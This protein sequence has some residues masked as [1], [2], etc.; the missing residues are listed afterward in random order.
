M[1]HSNWVDRARRFL[2]NELENSTRAT[3]EPELRI[4]VMDIHAALED[5]FRS[6][7]DAKF[8]EKGAL[9]KR[10]TSFPEI[11]GLLRQHTNVLGDEETVQNL[12]HFNRLRNSVVHDR[13]TP[14][15]AETL[16]FAE[17][18]STILKKLLEDQPVGVVRGTTERIRGYSHS[19]MQRVS[20]ITGRTEDSPPGLWHS[21]TS[22]AIAGVIVFVGGPLVLIVLAAA[23]YGGIVGVTEFGSSFITLLVF[24]IVG[25]I[26]G[27]IA[28]ILIAGIIVFPTGEEIILGAILAIIGGVLGFLSAFVSWITSAIAGPIISLKWWSTNRNSII[29]LNISLTALLWGGISVVIGIT[30]EA[31]RSA[32]FLLFAGSAFVGSLVTGV[33]EYLRW[34][35]PDTE[36]SD[37]KEEQEA[38]PPGLSKAVGVGSIPSLHLPAPTPTFASEELEQGF[39]QDL[40]DLFKTELDKRRNIR[41]DVEIN[42]VKVAAVVGKKGY[43][44]TFAATLET[45]LVAWKATDGLDELYVIA[46]RIQGARYSGN[47]GGIYALCTHEKTCKWPFTDT[48]FECLM[49]DKRNI[50]FKRVAIA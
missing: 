27:L 21:L 44:F 11:I 50:K 49:E 12:Y 43:L 33:T 6:Y 8:G 9:D 26:V 5:V 36:V 1:A 37:N 34:A 47:K 2:D 15:R 13:R 25:L 18:A 35:E 29:I 19:A 30:A 48:D 17:C 41:W 46:W 4:A 38:S 22:G 10:E 24:G 42:G 16:R 23:V 39:F 40:L 31:S 7:L 32:L 28:G 14:T 3:T 45:D 20:S